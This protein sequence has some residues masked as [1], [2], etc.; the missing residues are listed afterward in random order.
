VIRLA[1]DIDSISISIIE[2][3]STH[4]E[5]YTM[6]NMY[7]RSKFYD[8]D[9]SYGKCYASFAFDDAHN[10]KMFYSEYDTDDLLEKS[11]VKEKISDEDERVSWKATLVVRLNLD[12]YNTVENKPFG[13]DFSEI[14][15]KLNQYTKRIFLDM[16]GISPV[17]DDISCAGLEVKIYANELYMNGTLEEGDMIFCK[18]KDDMYG[19][20]ADSYWGLRSTNKYITRY[21]C[22]TW[23]WKTGKS[24]CSNV[25]DIAKICR[26]KI[27]NG[28]P[29]LLDVK[30]FTKE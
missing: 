13:E 26:C 17:D 4:K 14:L 29:T 21:M 28:K 27:V 3:V 19:L 20:V 9:S 7:S 15:F 10:L 16:K 22:E 8:Y 11:Y 25:P 30:D 24:L 18:G 2:N 6:V 23:H 5:F 1:T 12:R